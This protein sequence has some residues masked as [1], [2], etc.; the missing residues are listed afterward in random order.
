[1]VADVGA[2]RCRG[3]NLPQRASELSG[4]RMAK[5]AIIGAGWYGC[6]TANLMDSLGWDIHLF[7]KEDRIFSGAS[8]NNQFRLHLGFHYARSFS[9]RNQTRDGFNRFLERYNSLISPSPDSNL[10]AVSQHESL[11]DLETY[12]AIM[13]SSGLQSRAVDASAYGLHHVSG[14]VAVDE[15]LIYTE[16][17]VDY[18]T[19]K[20]GSKI[21]FGTPAGPIC[22]TADGGVSVGSERFDY[23]VDAT[24]GT[25]FAEQFREEYYFEP[26]LLMFYEGTPDFFALTLVDGDLFSIYPVAD[27]LFTLSSVRHTPLGQYPSFQEAQARLDAVDKNEVAALRE[28]ME[29]EA[30]VY[31]PAF[32]DTFRFAGVQKSVKTKF[33]AKTAFRACVVRRQHTIYSLFLEKIDTIFFA[34]NA[35]ISDIVN[36]K[37][38]NVSAIESDQ[39]AIF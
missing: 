35:I 3:K 27:N 22:H 31:F 32:R 6:H 13:S 7:E 37:D 18:F 4:N 34:A 19:K 23:V 24:W 17:A 38:G 2:E 1:M 28:A 10:Y 5:V 14:A 9:T 33:F 16:K 36:V 25:L 39:F 15:R 21:H 20:L 26:A 12:L 29:S 30:M 8:G 11:I